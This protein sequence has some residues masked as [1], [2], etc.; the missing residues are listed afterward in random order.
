MKVAG[1]AASLLLCGG[2]ELALA[3]RLLRAPPLGDVLGDEAEERL[4]RRG[5]AT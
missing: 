1:E 2:V 4:C 3:Q 5:S